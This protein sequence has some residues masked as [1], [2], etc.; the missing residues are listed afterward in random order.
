MAKV[1]IGMCTGGEIQARTMLSLLGLLGHLQ[2]EMVFSLQI[3]GY[4]PYNMGKLVDEAQTHECTHL[5]SIDTDMIFPPDGLDK[6]LAHDK[7]IVGANYNAR[8][9]YKD[10]NS[11]WS[12]IKFGKK[13]DYKAVKGT[14]I[15]KEL[16]ECAAVGLG[17]TLINMKV[18][19]ILQQPY[20]RTR[21]TTDGLATE[22]TVLCEDA[23]SSGFKVFCDPTIPMGHIGN[24]VY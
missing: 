14:D 20:F 23:I 24:Y 22:D 12:V 21:E 18:F 2:T 1:L 7:D 10:Q 4:K 5:L 15:P 6:L 11:P 16:F 17:F 3:G 9:S 19:T 13:G 8:G